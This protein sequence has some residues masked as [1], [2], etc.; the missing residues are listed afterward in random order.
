MREPEDVTRFKE[1]KALS[2]VMWLHMFVVTQRGFLKVRPRV[3]QEDPVSLFVMLSGDMSMAALQDQPAFAEGG[4]CALDNPTMGA[5]SPS[6]IHVR[7]DFEV[8]S[9]D[10]EDLLDSP[11]SERTAISMTGA[12][13]VSIVVPVP[14]HCG[15]N[16]A[17][18]TLAAVKS[19]C[20][21]GSESGSLVDLMG[22]HPMVGAS[23]L[24]S[25][26]EPESFRIHLRGLGAL[27]RFILENLTR[28][29]ATFGRPDGGAGC[30]RRSGDGVLEMFDAAM[31]NA[32]RA[33]LFETDML[34]NG[35]VMD[36]QKRRRE[37]GVY[38]VEAK[39]LSR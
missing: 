25:G 39:E 29:G 13:V 24:P 26:W 12:S 27:S 15:P 30:L 21:P 17:E 28:H 22:K 7:L 8:P 16:R 5:S 34:R 32:V 31:A 38:R 19:W 18:I 6:V 4:A 14:F 9:G 35:C 23:L 11:V 36:V 33:A 20:P 1:A 2:F 37:L 3:E 10:V